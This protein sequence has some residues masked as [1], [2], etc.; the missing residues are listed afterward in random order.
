VQVPPGIRAGPRPGARGMAS[1]TNLGVG[2]PPSID[3]RPRALRSAL[4]NTARFA[5]R[6]STGPSLRVEF[7]SYLGALR[8][9]ANVDRQERFLKKKMNDIRKELWGA[10]AN[11][12]V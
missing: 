4:R 9:V 6:S 12:L 2:H 1:P 3:R 10:N 11:Q 5:W 8:D 7:D